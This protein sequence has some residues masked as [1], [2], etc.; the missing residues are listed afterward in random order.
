MALAVYTRDRLAPSENSAVR[1]LLDR[2]FEGDFGDWDWQHA[3]GG[4]HA[5]AVEAD[6]IV[7]H[8]ALVPRALTVGDAPV[9]AGYVE[10]VAVEPQRQGQGLGSAVMRALE[11]AMDVYQLCALS[12]GEHAF[13][14]RLG[15]RSWRG[16]T[17]VR[18]PAGL[19]RTADEDAGIMVRPSGD[20]GELDVTAALTCEQ[21]EGDDW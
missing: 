8:A 13:Y 5:I 12:T 21:R 19:V 17:W 7:A 3:L 9:D 20:G 18:T 10:A 15:W 16:P 14:R 4:I 11:P 2:A 1:G 6:V